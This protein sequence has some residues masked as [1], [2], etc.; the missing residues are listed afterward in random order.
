MSQIALLSGSGLAGNAAATLISTVIGD[1]NTQP[2]ALM[3]VFD[4]TFVGGTTPTLQLILE[5]VDPVS[6]KFVQWGTAFTAVN[7][8]GTFTYVVA[9]GVGAASGGVTATVNLPVPTFFRVRTVAGGTIGTVSFTAT[10]FIIP[11][12]N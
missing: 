10:G 8:N 2:Y 12:N 1:S 3:I 4:V 9:L 11:L 5:A 6:G 7:A